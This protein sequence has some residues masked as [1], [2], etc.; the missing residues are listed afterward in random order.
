MMF[1]LL[2]LCAVLTFVK[3]FTSQ[4]R[5]YPPFYGD[6]CPGVTIINLENMMEP[7][8]QVVIEQ[9][10]RLVQYCRENSPAK[11]G[12]I[13]T[14][15]NYY[16][17][18]DLIEARNSRITVRIK[19]IFLHITATEKY[20]DQEIIFQ[21]VKVLPDMLNTDAAQWTYKN[22]ETLIIKIPYRVPLG[23]LSKSCPVVNKYAI[24]VPHVPESEFDYNFQDWT[25]NGHNAPPGRPSGSNYGSHI[26][27][28]M[29]TMLHQVVA[30]G[31]IMGLSIGQKMDT[32]LHPVIPLDLTMGLRIRHK[33]CIM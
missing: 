15:N 22:E 12:Q 33:M 3:P 21:D 18:Y 6:R 2:V 24:D 9:E 7:I 10:E 23:T 26:G 30:L 29:D 32:M 20:D 4:C 13:Y 1:R 16:L 27:H 19:H 28:K 5:N 14:T 17:I 11:I 8:E 31:S 25:Q